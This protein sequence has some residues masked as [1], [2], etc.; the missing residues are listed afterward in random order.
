MCNVNTFPQYFEIFRQGQ[1][2]F[3]ESFKTKYGKS[4]PITKK[5]KLVASYNSCF[6]YCDRQTYRIEVQFRH[7]LF[8][9]IINFTSKC[10]GGRFGPG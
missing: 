5:Q 10:V 1:P 8:A 6:V 9:F 2:L 7:R 4:V 3:Y